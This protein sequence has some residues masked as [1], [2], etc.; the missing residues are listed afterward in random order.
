MRKK[1]VLIGLFAVG[2]ISNVL[3][4]SVFYKGKEM[5]QA[6]E[7]DIDIS[8]VMMRWGK[9][10]DGQHERFIGTIA[11]DSVRKR[12]T[13]VFEGKTRDQS[14]RINIP[15]DIHMFGVGRTPVCL[16]CGARENQVGQSVYSRGA[17]TSR[18]HYF[19]AAVDLPEGLNY[20]NLVDV[21]SG[22]QSLR[23]IVKFNISPAINRTSFKVP[24]PPQASLHSTTISV[25]VMEPETAPT[26]SPQS[27]VPSPPM[28]GAVQTSVFLSA[29]EVSKACIA[30]DALDNMNRGDNAEVKSLVNAIRSVLLKNESSTN[31]R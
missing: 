24:I 27:S 30:L 1:T 8:V 26:L 29:D 20:L 16:T 12:I 15:T 21:I 23:Y 13:L 18:G 19:D 28:G 14:V 10:D 25:R 22:N 6:S 2:L 5:P 7:Q 31:S 3:A 9:T 4:V 11:S 17:K